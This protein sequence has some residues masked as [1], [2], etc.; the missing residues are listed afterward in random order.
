MRQPLLFINYSAIL[1]FENK[2]AYGAKFLFKVDLKG[3]LAKPNCPSGQSLKKISL[4]SALKG[5]TA[6]QH[7]QF[8]FL[9]RALQQLFSKRQNLQKQ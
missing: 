2:R 7:T 6:A 8:G 4:R 1:A 9:N 5:N 3:N